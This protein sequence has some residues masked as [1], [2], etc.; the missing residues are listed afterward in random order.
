[1]RKGSRAESPPEAHSAASHATDLLTFD[2]LGSIL[3]SDNVEL[4][5]AGLAR[6]TKSCAKI[7][8]QH[9]DSQVSAEADLL[10]AYLKRSPD[11][12]D[13]FRIWEWQQSV[14]HLGVDLGFGKKE[15]PP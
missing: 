9:V 5:H 7:A 3:M 4:L 14:R 12:S 15:R 11:V 10:R 1:M 2:E 8:K 6:F 13:L